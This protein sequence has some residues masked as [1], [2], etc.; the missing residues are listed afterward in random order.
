MKLA[1]HFAKLSKSL[2]SPWE[3]LSG[4]GAVRELRIDWRFAPA[5]PF[6]LLSGFGASS[7]YLLSVLLS[8]YL[9]GNIK[10]GYVL[11]A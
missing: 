4:S 6:S 8:A 9:C 3:H 2:G 1:V 10:A 7:A 11:S 5:V